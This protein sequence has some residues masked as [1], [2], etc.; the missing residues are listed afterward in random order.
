MPTVAETLRAGREAK[1]LTVQQVADATKMRTDHVRALEDGNFS[2]FSA[3]IY[4]RGSV[5]NYANFLKLDLSRIQPVLEAELKGS[6]KFSE[7]PPLSPQQQTFVDRL[8]LALA[9]VNWKVGVAGLAT[10]TGLILMAMIFLSLRHRQH[11]DPMAGVKPGIYHPAND[12]DTL[13]LPRR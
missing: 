4:I 6:E 8:T 7:P 1:Q 10:V 13:A 11:S 12:G 5:K 2:V 9:K 3:P